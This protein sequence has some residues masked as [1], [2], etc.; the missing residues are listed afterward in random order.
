MIPVRIECHDREL[1]CVEDTHNAPRLFCGN[2][3]KPLYPLACLLTMQTPHQGGSAI[4]IHGLP[5]I[6]LLNREVRP[7]DPAS[8]PL[9]RKHRVVDS[10][11]G[12]LHR[13]FDDLTSCGVHGQCWLA[14]C[15]CICQKDYAVLRHDDR[16]SEH[17]GIDNHFQCT[18]PG[19]SGT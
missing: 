13:R 14:E 16:R 17:N 12:P 4:S 7:R 5:E 11:P 1:A 8:G 2:D 10:R 3:E 9:L 18:R 15:C 19:G 6:I